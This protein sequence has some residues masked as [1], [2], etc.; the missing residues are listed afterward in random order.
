MRRIPQ[1]V[2]G[3]VAQLQEV[4]AQGWRLGRAGLQHLPGDAFGIVADPFQ[5]PVDLNGRENESQIPCHRLMPRQ[6]FQTQP[7]QLFLQ[8][9]NE[10]V[11]K[12]DRIGRLAIP[13]GQRPEAC[14][15]RSLAPPGH[16]RHF[17]ADGVQVP[18]QRF[19]QMWM[20]VQS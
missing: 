17:A 7:V 11:P 2:H 15:E 20:R 14:L 16:F 5:L 19:F 13:F 3:Q 9:V 18:L 8:F 10:L 1:H 12:N 4:F 6:E